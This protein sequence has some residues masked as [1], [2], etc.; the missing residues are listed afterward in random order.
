MLASVSMLDFEDKETYLVEG[1]INGNPFYIESNNFFFIFLRFE[2][3][4]RCI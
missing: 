2:K 1:E 4:N 3:N